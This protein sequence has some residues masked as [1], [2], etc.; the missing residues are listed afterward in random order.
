MNKN[1]TSLS[2]VPYRIRTCI[3]RVFGAR[4]EMAG[5]CKVGEKL[6]V[7]VASESSG[8]GMKCSQSMRKTSSLALLLVTVEDQGSRHVAACLDRRASA[9]CCDRA[10]S[11]GLQAIGVRA[12][13]RVVWRW[14]EEISNCYNA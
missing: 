10:R 4:E 8:R 1:K 6:L 7:A 5:L 13:W 11:D 2:I 14:V 3:K 12:A 9:G